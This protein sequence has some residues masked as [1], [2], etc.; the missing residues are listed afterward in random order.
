MKDIQKK[1]SKLQA[2]DIIHK[3]DDAF[4]KGEFR[5]CCHLVGITDEMAES[6][7][8]QEILEAMIVRLSDLC[9]IAGILES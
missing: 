3:Y 7:T 4:D 8:H 9:R 6:M 1:V 2:L 5:I